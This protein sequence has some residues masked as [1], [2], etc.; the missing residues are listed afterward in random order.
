MSSAEST[1]KKEAAW[2]DNARLEI[3]DGVAW[4]TLNRPD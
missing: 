1:S 4:V 3:V 2:G